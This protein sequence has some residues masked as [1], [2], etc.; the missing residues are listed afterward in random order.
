M[1]EIIS[2]LSTTLASSN[3]LLTALRDTEDWEVIQFIRHY[4][5][6]HELDVNERNEEGVT[7]LMLIAGLGKTELV[8]QLI[9]AGADLD[10]KCKNG[11]TA[12]LYA[13]ANDHLS[14]VRVLLQ[15]KTH[16]VQAA[17]NFGQTG[18]MLSAVK[19][20]AAIIKA[21][22]DAG[23]DVDAVTCQGHTA[24]MMAIYYNH[25]HMVEIL[26]EAGADVDIS[27]KNGMTALMWAARRGY[28]ASVVT[29]I[30]ADA[31]L[32]KV[33]QHGKTALALAN[34]KK[35]YH[36]VRLLEAKQI[37][38]RKKA[39]WV[40][41]HTRLSQVKWDLINSNQISLP[42]Y[43]VLWGEIFQLQQILQNLLR[44]TGCR[45]PI[46]PILFTTEDKEVDKGGYLEERIT[47]L[48][49][50]IRGYGTSLSPEK[51]QLTE[52]ISY[53][54][55]STQPSDRK[56]KDKE[57]ETLESIK[58]PRIESKMEKEMNITPSLGHMM[59]SES[60]E[61]TEP[62]CE[63]SKTQIHSIFRRPSC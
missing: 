32:N 28:T 3:T 33:N 52:A 27:Q 17:D 10:A 47:A 1:G 6:D 37:A 60:S 18:L 35:H 45:V 14:V 43:Q 5:F 40:S 23:A 51:T 57:E 49:E 42:C 9:T 31:D 7:L 34:K 38:M 2:H 61:M 8:E 36:I 13:I 30:N 15:H 11:W 62:S 50:H 54:V 12:L 59:W 46:M 58:R 22:I 63:D 21:L 44:S 25:I 20:N 26:L 48:E 16:L 29:F 4:H 39:Q 53:N 55:L 41:L 24:L 56:R 19:N